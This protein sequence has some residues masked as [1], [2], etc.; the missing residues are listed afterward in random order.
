MW[1]LLAAHQE[2]GKT[3]RYSSTGWTEHLQGLLHRTLFPLSA[4]IYFCGQALV[5]GSTHAIKRHDTKD[6]SQALVILVKYA[7]RNSSVE[8][9]G[10]IRDHHG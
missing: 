7:P 5:T 1:A 2:N 3:F 4:T 10:W 8:A 9:T 6:Q